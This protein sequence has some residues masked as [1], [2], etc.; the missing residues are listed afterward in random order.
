MRILRASHTLRTLACSCSPHHSEH[1]V[2]AAFCGTEINKQ[3]ERLDD[4][5]G[6]LTLEMIC[7]Q[8]KLFLLHPGV[9][10]DLISWKE[11]LNNDSQKIK[12]RV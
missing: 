6:A 3:R 11:E 2:I 7:Y 9:Y 8:M 10:V 1:L 4:V 12:E 5:S